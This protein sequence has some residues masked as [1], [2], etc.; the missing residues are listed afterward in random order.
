MTDTKNKFL[1][2]NNFDNTSNVIPQNNFQINQN[3]Q[4][5]MQL[6]NNMGMNSMNNMS[7]MHPSRLRHQAANVLF[8]ADLPDET[9]EEDLMG[10]FKDYQYKVSRVTNTPNRTYALVH[11]NSVEWAE[12]A[13]N[14]LNGV[15]ISA[16]YSSINISKPIRLCRWE[17]KISINERKDDD[18]KKNLLVKNLNKEISAHYFWN[19]FK[20]Y[21]DVRSSKLSIDFAGLSKGFGYITFYNLHDAEKAREALNNTEIAGKNISIEFLQP[22]LKKKIKK[23]NIYV[24]RF[25]KENFT[26][27]DLKKLFEVYGELVSVL[28]APDNTDKD[29]DKDKNKGFGFVCFRN[30]DNAEKAQQEL[31]NK[32]I[33]EDQK[34]PLYVDFAM[35]KDER[36]E[37]FQKLNR[38]SS[39]MTVFC[40]V[41]EGFNFENDSEFHE[42]IMKYLKMY[43]GQTYNPRYI[44]TRIETKT[45]FITLNSANEVEQFINYISDLGKT[46]NLGL[47]FNTY[48]SKVERINASNVMKKKYLTRKK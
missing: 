3:T 33:W 4:P 46:Q 22:G 1:N 24:K 17:T 45:A 47:Y 5:N 10:L 42:E 31:N 30:A 18:Y 28:V 20:A 23:N 36:M 2:Y 48:K 32:K 11:F 25:P 21:G 44:K 27:E 34:Y 37:H 15:K 39:R 16:K 13:R 38:N 12:K 43:F 6:S 19:I 26:Q 40:K 7:Q 41:K 8:V 14:D 29:N 35:K 9:C